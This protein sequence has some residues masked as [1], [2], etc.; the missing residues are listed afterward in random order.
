MMFKVVSRLLAMQFPPYILSK[1]WQ[2]TRQFHPKKL[3]Q[4]SSKTNNTKTVLSHVKSETGMLYQKEK[5]VSGGFQNGCH[6]PYLKL[7]TPELYYYFFIINFTYLRLTPWLYFN[8]STGTFAH[9]LWFGTPSHITW[10]ELEH[11]LYAL[12]LCL[13]SDYWDICQIALNIKH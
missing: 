4:I 7:L 12:F 2:S 8:I 5:A 6:V 10:L 13:N 3:I 11:L 9:L 1:R